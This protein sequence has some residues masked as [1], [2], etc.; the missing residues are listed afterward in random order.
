MLEWVD[1]NKE[2]IF[3]GIGIGVVSGFVGFFSVVLTL[4]AQR[5][6]AKRNRKRLLIARDATHFRIPK[7][8]Y[9]SEIENSALKVSYKGKEYDNLCFVGFFAN[10]IGVKAIDNLKLILQI[11]SSVFVVDSITEKNSGQINIDVETIKFKDHHETAFTFSRL[12]PKDSVRL[13][14]LID[15]DDPDILSIQPRGVDDL[16]YFVTKEGTKSDAEFLIGMLALFVFANAIPL[17]GNIAQ[18][19]VILFSAPVLVRFVRE[20]FAESF[21][22]QSSINIGGD[23]EVQPNASF[24]L[25]QGTRWRN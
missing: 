15:N 24:N 3:S 23:V 20:N 13:S 8:D 7:F 6:A 18:A 16:E 22:K 14:V 21:A 19:G 4:W 25:Q 12:E 2:W 9:E 5:R 11:P 1:Q 17:I 10:N